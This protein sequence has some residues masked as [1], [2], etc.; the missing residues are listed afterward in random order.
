MRVNKINKLYSEYPSEEIV[1]R[2]KD[3]AP[4]IDVINEIAPVGGTLTVGNGST[5]SP[6]I[7]GT[8][9]I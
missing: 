8:G 9:I 5:S 7:T 6:S 1:V 3:I 2:A 4:I